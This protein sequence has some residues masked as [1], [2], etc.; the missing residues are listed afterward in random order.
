MGKSLEGNYKS[1]KRSA[2][3][4]CANVSKSLGNTETVLDALRVRLMEEREKSVGSTFAQEVVVLHQ[5]ISK[6]SLIIFQDKILLKVGNILAVPHLNED[7][8]CVGGNLRLQSLK[9]EEATAS[10]KAN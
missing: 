3:R 10:P 1:P 4:L 8:P 5:K 2:L 7:L 6:C 9:R